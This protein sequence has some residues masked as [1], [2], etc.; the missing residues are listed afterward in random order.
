MYDGSYASELLFKALSQSL[1]VNAR[2]YR[3]NNKG[4]KIC[5]MHIQRR[6]YIT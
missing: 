3:G 4:C 5:L 1:E 2:T 6:V